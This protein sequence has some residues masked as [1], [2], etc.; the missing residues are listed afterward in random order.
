MKKIIIFQDLIPYLPVFR[1]RLRGTGA[2]DEICVNFNDLQKR[3]D[4]HTLGAIIDTGMKGWDLGRM[5]DLMESQQQKKW[6][7]MDSAQK[8]P[9]DI[10][11]EKILRCTE[12]KLFQEKLGQFL[13]LS[14]G[15]DMDSYL[16]ACTKRAEKKTEPETAPP[17]AEKRAAKRFTI[18]EPAQ[19]A[20]MGSQSIIHLNP[21]FVL[22]ISENGVL[23]SV[24]QKLSKKSYVLD[25][26]LPGDE[27]AMKFPMELV[28]Y[29]ALD[30]EKGGFSHAHAFKFR[31][32]N[33]EQLDYFFSYAAR[34]EK[35]DGFV[36]SAADEAFV[37]ESL[38]A[39]WKSL[40]PRL[41]QSE[42]R[43]G[44]FRFLEAFTD[45]EKE[46]VKSKDEIGGRILQVLVLKAKLGLLVDIAGHISGL[47]TETAS[48]QKYVSFA[49]NNIRYLEEI[50]N[51]LEAEVRKT[52]DAG[53]MERRQGLNDA[54]N[55]LHGL[56]VKFFYVLESLFPLSQWGDVFPELERVHE[57]VRVD[58][59]SKSGSDDNVKYARRRREPEK[60]KDEQ[61]KT[62]KGNEKKG[63]GLLIFSLSLAGFL[64]LAKVVSF[65]LS[66][67]PS[68]DVG[69]D[70]DVQSIT[71]D[72]EGI[73]VVMARDQWRDFGEEKKAQAFE[74]SEAFLTEEGLRQLKFVDGKGRRIAAT[75]VI[76]KRNDKAPVY[77]R[78]EF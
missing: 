46:C 6:V 41:T 23:L 60:K 48:G 39:D 49:Q 42:A 61:T 2:R 69:Y 27:E 7:L 33:D 22:N 8:L 71:R 75:V 43:D 66:F 16:Q 17:D 76:R 62:Q 64:V 44:R 18:L 53:E 68:S 31:P 40:L 78:R 54:S 57:Y 26:M 4:E 10:V 30:V 12:V 38:A 35:K 72:D 56:K 3:I 28:R 55:R 34:F 5:L 29:K 74:K 25:L 51:T 11:G 58:R 47:G 67:V 50:E 15:V 21:C 24:P 77:G 1:D 32:L 19:F 63:K 36:L 13:L 70:F 45:F 37:W 59:E 73:V 52:V 65:V 9:E 14:M 20:L